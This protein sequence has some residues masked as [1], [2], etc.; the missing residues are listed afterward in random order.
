MSPYY[1]RPVTIP[2]MA[3]PHLMMLASVPDAHLLRCLKGAP[4]A[5]ASDI[6][7]SHWNLR[8]WARRQDHLD[9]PAFPPAAPAEAAT[10]EAEV[11]AE[12]ITTG[13]AADLLG[14][15]RRT[16][17]NMANDGRLEGQQEQEGGHWMIDKASAMR[18]L[19]SR[20]QREDRA[21]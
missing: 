14:V 9:L 4:T 10:T 21:A 8:A 20:Q 13:Q 15:D 12:W 3:L 11:V 7:R 2:V 18:Y 1:E 6:I 16:V 17:T 5:I 19:A